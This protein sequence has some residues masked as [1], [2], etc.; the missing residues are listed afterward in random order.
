[1]AA[2]VDKL[3]TIGERL[4]GLASLTVSAGGITATVTPAPSAAPQQQPAP[5]P[6]CRA[7]GR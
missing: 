5:V 3:A 7:C 2:V 4:P 1:M 6:A